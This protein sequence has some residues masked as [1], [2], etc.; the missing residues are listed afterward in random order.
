MNERM[1]IEHNG[2][3]LYLGDLNFVLGGV[4]FARGR[5]LCIVLCCVPCCV[6]YVFCPGSMC[7]VWMRVLYVKITKRKLS[8]V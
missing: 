4:C 7:N 3:E 5:H 8:R 6:V 2:K 1:R